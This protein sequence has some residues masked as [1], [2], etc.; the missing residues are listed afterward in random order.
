VDPSVPEPTSDDEISNFSRSD[1]AGFVVNMW[2]QEEA[3]SYWEAVNGLNGQL[4]KE[5]VDKELDS[6]DRART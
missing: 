6:S 5:V 1:E 2:E 3:K 4:W